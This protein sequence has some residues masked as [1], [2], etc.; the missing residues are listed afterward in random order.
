MKHILLYCILPFLFS[1]QI[2]QTNKFNRIVQEWRGKEIILPIDI[3]CTHLGR[4]TLY[5]ELWNNSHKIFTYIDSIGCTSCQLGLPQWK[6][7]IDSCIR[8]YVDVHFV[9]VVH[10]TNYR[11][12][13]QE[14][15]LNDF[16]YP[17]IYDRHND[18][19]KLNHFPPAP[20][21]TFLLDKD[22]KVLLVGSPINNPTMWELYKKFITQSP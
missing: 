15:R 16:T 3:E 2:S 14:L 12:F 1:C 20:Y 6:Q 22:N 21:R 10:S 11:Q 19:D 17:V 4:D 7:L 13:G 9:F 5:P 18:F 8:Q